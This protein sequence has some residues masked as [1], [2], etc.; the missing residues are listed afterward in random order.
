MKKLILL[1]AIAGFFTQTQ[2]QK[3]MASDV[4]KVVTAA[5]TKAHSTVTDV[6]WSKDGVNFEAEYDVNKADM[7]TTYSAAGIMIETEME[8]A[9]TALPASV[10]SYVETNYKEK[11]ISEASKITAANGTVTY[12]AEVTGIDLI[13]DAKGTFIKTVKD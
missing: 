10:L 2:A 9:I 3:L 13:F 5:F 7:S 12:E 4:P 6:A 8:I 11:E 1:L